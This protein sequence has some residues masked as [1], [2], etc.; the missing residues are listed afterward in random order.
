MKI[1]YSIAR[2]INTQNYENIRIEYEL[3]G[4]IKDEQK[5]I[6]KVEKF[7]EEKEKEIREQLDGQ[8]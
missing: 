8:V 2:V 5:L 4:D 6:E 7:I 3:E 1:K